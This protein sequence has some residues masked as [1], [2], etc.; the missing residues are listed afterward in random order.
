MNFVFDFGAVLFTLPL[1]ALVHEQLADVAPGP[2]AADAWADRMFGH[3]DWHAFDRGHLTL[4]EV[5]ERHA[6][7]FGLA[8]ERLEQLFAAIPDRLLP[9]APSVD[10][11]ARLKALRDADGGLRLFYLSNMPEPYARILEQRYDFLRWFDGGIFSGDVQA[12]KPEARIYHLLAERHDLAPERTVF[13]DDMPANVQAAQAL[14]WRGTPCPWPRE[15]EAE[16]LKRLA[17]PARV[18]AA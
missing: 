17:P 2:A 11:L 3:E 4:D 9:I 14:G 1:R 7:H 6:R 8:R 16:V 13:I 12:I 5:T 15:L 18:H 10:L